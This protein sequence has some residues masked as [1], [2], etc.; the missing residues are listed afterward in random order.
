[1]TPMVQK[2]VN[3]QPFYSLGLSSVTLEAGQMYV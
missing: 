3:S 1:M 2:T